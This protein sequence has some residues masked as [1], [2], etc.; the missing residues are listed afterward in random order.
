[1]K[2]GLNLGHSGSS[3][4]KPELDMRLE[5][6]KGKGRCQKMKKE[7]ERDEDRKR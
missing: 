7:K 5:G 1:M 6:K 2:S 3:F 4:D